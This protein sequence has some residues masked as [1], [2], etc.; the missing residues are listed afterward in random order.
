[1]KRFFI[2]TALLLLL[3]LSLSC[4]KGSRA[5][6]TVSVCIQNDTDYII[7]LTCISEASETYYPEAV[8][9]EARSSWVSDMY[10]GA[11]ADVHGKDIV[12]VYPFPAPDSLIVSVCG[13]S[14]KQSAHDGPENGLCNNDNYSETT[15]NNHT[16][17]TFIISDALLAEWLQAAY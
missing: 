7:G 10:E 13:R 11:P 5:A 16:T 1:M 3:P 17:F 2:Y 6:W 4:G 9:I 15:E 14:V 8:E 12:C